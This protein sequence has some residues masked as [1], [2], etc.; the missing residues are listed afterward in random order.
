MSSLSSISSWN[1]IWSLRRLSSSSTSW[2]KGLS[3]IFR[4]GLSS[5]ILKNMRYYCVMHSIQLPANA[6]YSAWSAI[7]A[8][9]SGSMS[10][11]SCIYTHPCG[12]TVSDAWCLLCVPM[13]SMNLLEYSNDKCNV[14]LAIRT[15]TGPARIRGPRT[16]FIAW[17]FTDG[18]VHI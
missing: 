3:A 7:K 8:L 9:I 4:N 1:S 11:G 13:L 5:A 14:L 6:R 15:R 10:L 18:H 12:E 2:R 17:N 16:L